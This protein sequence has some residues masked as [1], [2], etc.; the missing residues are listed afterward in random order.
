MVIAGVHGE[1]E[2]HKESND[3]QSEHSGRPHGQTYRLKKESGNR[4]GHKTKSPLCKC[5][6]FPAKDLDARFRLNFHTYIL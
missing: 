4:Y 2:I 3:E 6:D 1:G 5:S